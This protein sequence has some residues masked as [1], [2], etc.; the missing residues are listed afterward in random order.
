MRYIVMAMLTA[1][2]CLDPSMAQAARSNEARESLRG[3]P[4]VMVV[5]E[6][7]NPDAQADGLSQDAIRTAVEL[8]LR[9]SGIRVLTKSE[10]Q[11]PL[12]SPWLYVSIGTVKNSSGVYAYGLRF[13]FYQ[14][15]VTVHRPQQWL[16]AATWE[17]PGKFGTIGQLNLKR[18]VIDI[19]ET[20][21]KEFAN[22]FLAVNP[23]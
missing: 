18:E 4:G 10:E 3:F 9:A 13:V 17:P 5:I 20:M 22:D 6:G 19:L 11:A 23:R 14:T 8:I 15:V 21:V 16:Q 7:T 2:T 12:F 1:L